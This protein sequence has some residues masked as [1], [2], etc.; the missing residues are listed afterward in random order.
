MIS[1]IIAELA[2]KNQPLSIPLLKLKVVAKR[3]KND[4]LYDIV[5]KELEGYPQGS[6]IPEY[7]MAPASSYASIQQNWNIHYNQPLPLTIFEESIRNMLT[8]F[9]VTQGIE[10]LENIAKGDKNGTIIKEF[11][12]D[13]S[14]YLTSKANKKGADFIFGDVR[15]ST[16]VIQIVDIISKIRNKFLDL[17]LSIESDFP[18]IDDIINEPLNDD[19]EIKTKTN[20]YMAQIN[21]TNSGDGNVINTGNASEINASLTV[22][23]NDLKSLQESLRRIEVDEEDIKEISKIVKN[24]N[25]NH[26]EYKLGNKSQSWI[27]KMVGKALDGTWKIGVATSAGIL[28]KL[29]SSYYGIGQ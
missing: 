20:Q 26:K 1:K 28:A 15:M 17:V 29:I 25:Y 18:K 11:G 4:S 19:N 24:E 22:N 21:I 9:P 14:T 13:F 6:D 10:A 7:R 12:A 16:S 5:S 3:I 23:K 2:D 8:K 27:K